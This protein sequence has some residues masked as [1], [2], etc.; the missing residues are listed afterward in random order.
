MKL[1]QGIVLIVVLSSLSLAS[2]FAHACGHEGF[3]MGIGYAQLFQYTTEDENNLVASRRINFGPGYGASAVVGYD[4]KGSRW[5]IQLPFEYAALKLNRSEW[6]NS[7]SNEVEAILHLVEWS[8]GLDFHLVGGAGW[9]YLS[10]GSIN[11]QT[12]SFGVIASLGPGF[13]WFFSRTE[14]IS[15][16]LA[17]EIP[18]RFVHYF[19]DHLSK[20]GTT[21][22]AFPIRLTM[23]VGF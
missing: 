6:V 10:E 20:G 4:F 8:N 13:S 17:L 22:V 2:S 19:K 21:A 18:F 11:N 9:T 7:L 23:Q 3:F 5:G 14:K 16:A 1:K 15:G 12:K